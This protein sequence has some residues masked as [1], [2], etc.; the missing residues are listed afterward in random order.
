MREI[1]D[2]QNFRDKE[3]E[4]VFLIALIP[5]QTFLHHLIYHNC[6]LYSKRQQHISKYMSP[7]SLQILVTATLSRS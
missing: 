3:I 1:V 2:E 4:Q 6:S 5:P 7:A